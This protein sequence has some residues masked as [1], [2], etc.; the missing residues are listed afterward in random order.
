MP[1]AR[2]RADAADEIFA[3]GQI[4][5]SLVAEDETQRKQCL[6]G[7]PIVVVVVGSAAGRSDRGITASQ[8]SRALNRDVPRQPVLSGRAERQRGARYAE[9]LRRDIVIAAVEPP[10]AAIIRAGV[11]LPAYEKA[12]CHDI[13]ETIGARRGCLEREV[14]EG[15]AVGVPGLAR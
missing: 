2:G 8:Q 12:A 6:R 10:H 15:T 9:K 13:F 4:E 3:P 1:A 7:H 14:V 5:R 11:V